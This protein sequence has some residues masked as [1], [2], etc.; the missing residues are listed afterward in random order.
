MRGNIM[1]ADDK[2]IVGVAKCESYDAEEVRSALKLALSR[3]QMPA[4]NGDEV[5]IKANLLSPSTPENAVTTHP[6]VLRAIA[7]DLRAKGKTVHIADNPGYIFTDKDTLLRTT[8]IKALSG[9]GVGVS[10]L[11]DLGVRTVRNE[12]F[13]SLSEAR[14]SSRYLDARYVINA[15]KLKTHVETEITC[16]I[17]NIFGTADIATR[18]KCHQSASQSHLANAITDLFIIRP[19]EFNILDAV[20][21][22]EGDGPSHGRPRSVGW[23][24]AGTNALAIDWV[25]SLIMCYRDPLK[26][27]LINAA[28]SRGLGPKD[29]SEI[30]LDGAAWSDLPS[31]GFRKSSSAL[32]FVP[33]FLRGLVHSMVSLR[34]D[35]QRVKCVRCGICKKVC[36][37][38]AIGDDAESYPSINRTDCVKCLCCHEMCPTGAMTV[39]KNFLGKI[40]ARERGD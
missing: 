34:P 29:R 13:R 1:S 12:S 17:K 14:I 31:W 19:P 36:P 8:G 24:L 32:R 35:L 6:A 20:T 27:P 33:T 10:M 2:F 21:C 4:I 16:C 18:K 15:A 3:A 30:T 23:L 26:I 9:D 7:G 40:A 22:M 28:A 39:R 38:D 5:L 25:A 37:V 11:S